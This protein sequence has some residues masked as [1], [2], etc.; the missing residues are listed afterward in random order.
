MSKT[1]RTDAVVSR[2]DGELRTCD[3][4][5]WDEHHTLL[6]QRIE[7][8]DHARQLELE[9]AEARATI[10]RLEIRIDRFDRI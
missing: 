2:H 9:L 6:R 1:P 7:L 3:G 8:K 4:M 5:M 10:T